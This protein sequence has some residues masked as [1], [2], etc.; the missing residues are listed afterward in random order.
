MKN[1]L[2]IWLRPLDV[3]PGPTGFAGSVSPMGRI[4]LPLRR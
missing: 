1:V 2:K 3:T 4:N